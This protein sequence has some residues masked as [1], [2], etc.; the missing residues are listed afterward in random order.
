MIIFS[1]LDEFHGLNNRHL[2]A[3]RSAL[4]ESEARILEQSAIFGQGTLPTG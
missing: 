2:R 1:A 4:G 3:D